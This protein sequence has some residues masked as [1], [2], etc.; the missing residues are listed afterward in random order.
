[1]IFKKKKLINSEEYNQ[2]K[3][4]LDMLEIDIAVLGDKV[5]KAVQKKIIKREQPEPETE[6]S[7][8]T[9]SNL[10]LFLLSFSSKECSFKS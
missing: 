1:M 5:T 7:S 8:G 3:R 9:V 6:D 2:L 4:R 10:T